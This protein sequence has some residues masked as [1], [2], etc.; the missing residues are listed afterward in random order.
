MVRAGKN[1]AGIERKSQLEAAR[2][3][4]RKKL[5]GTITCSSTSRN[6]MPPPPICTEFKRLA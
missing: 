3:I 1:E 2:V 5:A 4:I 6:R